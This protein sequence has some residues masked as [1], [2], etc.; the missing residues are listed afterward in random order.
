MPEK[1]ECGRVARKL[2]VIFPVLA[3]VLILAGCST[4]FVP[5]NERDSSPARTTIETNHSPVNGMVQSHN[6][7]AVTIEIEWIGVQNDSLVLNVAMNTH[8]V[9]L[10]S[11]DLAELAVL[12]DDEGNEYRASSWDSAPGGHHRQGAIHFP[13]PPSL[14]QGTAKYVEMVIHNIAGIDERVLRWDL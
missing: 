10:D 8:S 14:S 7:G 2:V 13:V 5:T 3:L 12:R 6:G 1:R 9:D 11:Y 4:G